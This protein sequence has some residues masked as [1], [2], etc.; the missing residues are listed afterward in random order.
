M[1]IVRK[2]L[3]YLLLLIVMF[4]GGTI[5]LKIYDL[6]LK[7]GF[8]NILLSGFQVGLVAWIGW[9]FCDFHRYIKNKKQK[10]K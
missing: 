10:Q 6:I 8:E 5:V 1:N 7:L 4:I 3:L 9:L 2:I